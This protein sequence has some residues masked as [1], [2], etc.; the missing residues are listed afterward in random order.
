M[1]T[2]VHILTHYT[3]PWTHTLSWGTHAY[4]HTHALTYALTQRPT[5]TPTHNHTYIL[6][7]TTSQKKK[8]KTRDNKC[9]QGYGRKG[10]P[11]HFDKNVKISAASIGHI[12]E[13]PQ[14]I[15]LPTTWPSN[16]TSGNVF[17]IDFPHISWKPTRW[18]IHWQ[19]FRLF[20]NIGYCG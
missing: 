10:K 18:F 17:N 4:T 15:E 7:Y 8:K 9:W 13:V 1:S 20:P 5:H 16:L 14:K 3:I 12:M 6:K 19:T 2:C 11:V